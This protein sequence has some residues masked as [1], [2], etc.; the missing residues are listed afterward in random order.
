M[1]WFKHS[2]GSHDDPDISDLMDK[3]GDTGYGA[4]CSL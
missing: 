4:F 1:K 3:F 2:T